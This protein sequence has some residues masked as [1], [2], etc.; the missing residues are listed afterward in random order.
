MKQ[1]DLF[2]TTDDLDQD[3]LMDLSTDGSMPELLQE[4]DENFSN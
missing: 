4:L 1:K 3:H 2:A